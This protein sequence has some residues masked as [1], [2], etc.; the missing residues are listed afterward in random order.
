M[1]LG[2]AL[3][4]LTDVHA[5]LVEVVS[6]LCWFASVAHAVGDRRRRDEVIDM[7]GE[8]V[9]ERRLVGLAGAH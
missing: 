7:A 2:S 5:D 9:A 4:L 1:A 3:A 8:L 6:E